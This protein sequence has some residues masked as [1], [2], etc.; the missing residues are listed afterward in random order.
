MIGYS[1]KQLCIGGGIN[2]SFLALAPNESNPSSF[3]TF[4]PTFIFNVSYNI[5]SKILAL[6]LKKILPCIIYENQW[7]FVLGKQIFY[8][9]IMIHEAVDSSW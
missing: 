9:I 3:V 5:I 6:R 7:G 2:S 4:R 8:N 1:L